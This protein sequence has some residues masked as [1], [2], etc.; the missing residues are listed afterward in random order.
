MNNIIAIPEPT[1]IQR[2]IPFGVI[3]VF[4]VGGILLVR[5]NGVFKRILGIVLI[6]IGLYIA[7]NFYVSYEMW[8]NIQT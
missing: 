4:L 8:K 3:G 1:L 5:K 7:Y 6:I 2:L